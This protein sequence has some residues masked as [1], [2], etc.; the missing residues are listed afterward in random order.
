MLSDELN[1][2][3]IGGPTALLQIGGLRFIT[4]PTF[5]EKATQYGPE[6]TLEKLADPLIAPQ[7]LDKMDFV[8]L[9]TDQQA[10]HLDH[11]GREYLNYVEYVFTTPG[12]AM[13]LGNN[14]V[15]I[16]PW[17]SME[18]ETKDGRTVILVGTPCQQPDESGEC[19]TGFLLY[20]K[21]EPGGAVYITG[22][23]LLSEEIREV[24]RR[25]DVRL[26]LPF[27]GAAKLRNEGSQLQTM[28]ADDCI[29]LAVIFENAQIT[30]LNFEGWNHLTESAVQVRDA[31]EQAGLSSRLKWPY[32][33]NAR[34]IGQII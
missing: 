24:A 7:Q 34:K 10:A 21:D 3:Y 6:N 22:A 9:G 18:F 12:A 17:Q 4:D 27:L 14:T 26:V 25:F 13:R 5:D 16:Q 29:E 15:G 31:F 19:G 8:L 2:R 33:F 23:T 32:G 30:P 20:L 1:I 28:T 11:T